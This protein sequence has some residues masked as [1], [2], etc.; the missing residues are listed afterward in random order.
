MN[1]DSTA[2]KSTSCVSAPTV[3]TALSPTWRRV[4]R[5]QV[6]GFPDGNLAFPQSL[7]L[8]EALGPG[9]REH[10]EVGSVGAGWHP[11][12]YARSLV[13]LMKMGALLGWISSS[14]A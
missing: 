3:P 11:D 8:P 12:G 5:C 9:A 7:T 4:P 2:T 1:N 6:E 10:A 13:E 14:R